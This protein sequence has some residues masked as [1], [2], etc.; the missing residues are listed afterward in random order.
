MVGGRGQKQERNEDER[1]ELAVT[2]GTQEAFKGGSAQPC[3]W[4]NRK[5]FFLIPT[6]WWK[7]GGEHRMTD[8]IILIPL[9]VCSASSDRG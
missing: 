3:N 2:G 9:H 4:Q 7:E 1:K 5:A 6:T 8:K